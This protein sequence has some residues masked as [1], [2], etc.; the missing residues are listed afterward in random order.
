MDS[1]DYIDRN[2]YESMYD[3]SENGTVDMV[4]CGCLAENIHGSSRSLNLA[5]SGI[6]RG[7]NF[8][9]LKSNMMFDVQKGGPAVFQSVCSKIFRKDILAQVID[10]IDSEITIGEDAA[11]VYP[12]LLKAKKI[13][14]SDFC[15]YY[16][17]VN[18]NSMTHSKDSHIFERILVF[19]N[20]MSEYF[21]KYGEKYK[22]QQQLNRYLL[23]LIDMGTVNLYGIRH[24]KGRKLQ[25]C[26]ELDGKRVILYGAGKAGKEYYLQILKNESIKIVAWVDKKLADKEI[27]YQRIQKP[28]II[29]EIDFDYVLITVA[30]KKIADEIT[31]E[32]VR[33]CVPEKIIWYP[34]TV[35]YTGEI[36]FLDE[37]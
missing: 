33:F 10:S 28:E 9:E 7:D 6:Y 11:I 13:V 30:D 34:Y 25:L 18:D 17:T 20:Y 16:Y 21:K 14:L 3:M 22:L 2:T 15:F 12:F 4:G 5:D 32:I 24:K 23:H 19:Q 31:E 27:Y 1:D 8:E 35:Q 29:E 37:L 26:Q 36:E